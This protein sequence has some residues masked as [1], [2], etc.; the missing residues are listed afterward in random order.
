MYCSVCQLFID[1]YVHNVLSV[2]SL[3]HVTKDILDVT[4]HVTE[5]PRLCQ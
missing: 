4:Y 1:L 2:D 3:L 5:N